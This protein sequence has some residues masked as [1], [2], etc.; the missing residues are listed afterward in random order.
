MSGALVSMYMPRLASA[1]H[2]SS[3]KRRAAR[4]KQSSALGCKV[5]LIYEERTPQRRI[6]TRI[7]THIRSRVAN[8]GLVMPLRATSNSNPQDNVN[9]NPRL[10]KRRL[11][12][13]SLNCHSWSIVYTKPFLSPMRNMLRPT[14][15]RSGGRHKPV[16]SLSSL[17]EN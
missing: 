10:N 3:H 16:R 12:C 11:A 15:L 6:P 4:Q 13:N 1:A 9:P 7:Y 5:S 17:E 2:R 14:K 8:S